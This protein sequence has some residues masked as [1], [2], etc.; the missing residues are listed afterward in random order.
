MQELAQELGIERRLERF[1][2]AKVELNE[3]EFK[4]FPLHGQSRPTI[5]LLGVGMDVMDQVPGGMQGEKAAS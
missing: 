4:S 2:S 1:S 3:V 5:L